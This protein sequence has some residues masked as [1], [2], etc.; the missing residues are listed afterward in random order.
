MH[1]DR[2]TNTRQDQE[3]CRWTTRVAA[4]TAGSRADLNAA[5]SSIPVCGR[6]PMISLEVRGNGSDVTPASAW[7]GG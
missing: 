2:G 1:S 7:G 3:Q 6:V 4:I 5:L